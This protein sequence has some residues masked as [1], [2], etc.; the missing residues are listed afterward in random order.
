[1]AA[2]SAPPHSPFG[3]RAACPAQRPKVPLRHRRSTGADLAPI[4]AGLWQV[5]GGTTGTRAAGS[6]GPGPRSHPRRVRAESGS[7]IRSRK[8]RRSIGRADEPPEFD[9]APEG[10]ADRLLQARSGYAIG[11]NPSRKRPK[12]VRHWAEPEQEQ[13]AEMADLH[14]RSLG[15]AW[16]ETGSVGAFTSSRRD[17]FG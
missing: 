9:A 14:R 3:R 1:L 15:H 2:E 17:H 5:Q 4:P 7:T 8:N 12:W 11:R 16:S 13:A 10:D 6:L